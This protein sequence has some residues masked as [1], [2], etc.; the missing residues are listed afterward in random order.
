M[1]VL[2]TCRH[3]RVLT[4]AVLLPAGIS[5]AAGAATVSGPRAETTQ[6]HVGPSPTVIPG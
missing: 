3:R 6:A 2:G 5:T 4:A 1:Q